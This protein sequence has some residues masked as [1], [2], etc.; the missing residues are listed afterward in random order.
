MTV[1]TFVVD[2]ATRHSVFVQ[3]FAGSETLKAQATLDRMRQGVVSRLARDPT[4]FQANR[5]TALL[6]DIESTIA[7]VMGELSEQT[8]ET[9][10]EFAVQEAAFTVD[11]T[12][13]TTITGVALP[14]DSL[15]TQIVV[16]S[17]MSAPVGPTQITMQEALDQFAGKKAE[18]VINAIQDA[19]VRGDTL[20]T[21]VRDVRGIT[22][23]ET[24]RT[25]ATAQNKAIRDVED[26]INT[27]QKRQVEALTRTILNH[28]ANQAT[29]AVMIENEAI[30]D[31]EEWVATLDGRTTFICAGRDG[32]IFPPGQ[33][34]YPPAHWGCRS[35][36]V[37]IVKEEFAV[38]G[39][40]G[41]RGAVGAKLDKDGNLVTTRGQVRGDV[42]FGSWLKGQPAAF[43]DEYLGPAR[44]KLF[45]QGGLE[46]SAFRDET[47]RDFT[48]DQLRDMDP[49]A[50]AEAGLVEPPG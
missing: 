5:L 23:R 8:L 32:R 43:Q 16:R 21:I 13:K 46:I 41:R 28:T 36:R 38:K 27:R 44:G 19:A 39:I 45:R 11:L 26:L 30:L 2:A 34:P 50:F 37:P 40:T 7:A 18:E 48:L 49:V 10:E 1:E 14:S 22:G 29:K 35:R 17:G 25:A 42:N 9:V 4:D 47:G 33:G 6:R 20:E 3:R 15:L 31:G 12:Q 24:V